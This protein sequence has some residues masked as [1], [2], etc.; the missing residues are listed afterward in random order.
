MLFAVR[1]SSYQK[2]L[3]Q[4]RIRLRLTATPDGEGRREKEKLAISSSELVT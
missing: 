2:N 4:R 3:A 1:F